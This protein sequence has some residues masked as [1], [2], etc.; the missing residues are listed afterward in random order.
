MK[1]QTLFVSLALALSAC[2]SHTTHSSHDAAAR[3]KTGLSEEV[4]TR[5]LA[6]ADWNQMKTVSI[7][8]RDYGFTPRE[9]HL[10]SG[11]TYRLVITNNGSTSHYF[12]APEFLRNIASRKA[13]V[14]NQAEVKA[15]FFNSFELMRRG[16]SMELYFVPVTQGSYRAHCHLEGKEHDGVEGTLVIE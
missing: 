1:M 16:G 15:D 8:L 5:T 13:M 9:L 3:A 6:A 7:E 14:P 12:D 4:R 2:Q 11:Q 10:K